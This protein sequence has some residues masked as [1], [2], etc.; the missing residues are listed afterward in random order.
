MTARQQPEPGAVKEKQTSAK[1]AASRIDS[2]ARQLLLA[3]IVTRL[4]AQ[5][6]RSSGDNGATAPASE[7]P[8]TLPRQYIVEQVGEIKPLLRECYQMALD[9]NTDLQGTLKVRFTVVADEELGGLITD[10]QVVGGSATGNEGLNEGLVECIRET[11]YALRL[12]AP[13]HGG[14]VTV[15]YPFRF[16]RTAS[17]REEGR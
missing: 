13:E 14:K 9:G 16:S 15:T 4:A 11:M 1:P 3:T 2:Q 10:S 6:V 8:G 7:R 12:K 17:D 5:Q